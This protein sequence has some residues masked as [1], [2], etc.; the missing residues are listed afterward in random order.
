MLFY[1]AAGLSQATWNLVDEM[2]I[3]ACG[4]KIRM[5]AGL[6]MTETAP[7]AMFGA[8]ISARAG[9]V[10][11]PVPGCDMKLVPVDGKLEVRFRGRT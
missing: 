10:G 4:Q 9:E 1:A 2:A 6:G 3:A 5:T 8:S 7:M 11:V